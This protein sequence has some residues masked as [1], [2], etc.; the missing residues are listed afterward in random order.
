MSRCT[1]TMGGHQCEVDGEHDK[2]VGDNGGEV[3]VHFVTL[4]APEGHKGPD[5]QDDSGKPYTSSWYDP[6]LA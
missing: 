3:D 1:E 2:A 5:G 4:H 6:S